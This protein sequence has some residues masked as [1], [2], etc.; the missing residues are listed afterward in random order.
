MG[1]K[2]T[3]YEIHVKPNGLFY[4]IELVKKTRVL[5]LTISS[6]VIHMSV[7]RDWVKATDE[8]DKFIADNHLQDKVEFPECYASANIN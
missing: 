1:F 7:E 5:M 4:C 3:I 2:K 6:E 8:M